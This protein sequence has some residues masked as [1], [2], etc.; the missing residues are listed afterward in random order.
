MG[1]RGQ[2]LNGRVRTSKNPHCHKS[3]ENTENKKI[4]QNQCF[5][6]SGN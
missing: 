2:F 5:Q 6:N 3:Y 4:C 1:P